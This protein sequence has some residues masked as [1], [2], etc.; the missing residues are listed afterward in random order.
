M[1]SAASKKAISPTGT[2]IAAPAFRRAERDE[3]AHAKRQLFHPARLRTFE[4][5]ARAASDVAAL[6][7]AVALAGAASWVISTQ[8]FHAD[9]YAFSAAN[10]QH[11]FGLWAV[12]FL[13]LCSWFSATGAYSA[14]NPLQD[15]I[16]QVISAL[17]VMLIIDGFIQFVSKEEFSRLWIVLVWP[18]AAVLIP[19]SRVVGAALAEP[20]RL[21]AH[22]CGGYRRRLAFRLGGAIA[23]R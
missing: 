15:D 22:G 18:L 4:F 1:S 17:T 16:K 9:Y 11:R 8:I 5:L 3:G 6:C 10:L 7:A 21:L 2:V 20:V 13:G 12:L 19:V 14:R 23:G